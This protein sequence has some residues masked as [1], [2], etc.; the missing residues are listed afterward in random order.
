MCFSRTYGMQL[1]GLRYFNIFGPKQD[2]NGEYAAV[3]PLFIKAL[4]KNEAPF[5]N[6]DGEQ[7]RDFTYVHNAVQANVLAMFSHNELAYNQA[8]NIA[9][10]GRFSINYMYNAIQKNLEKDIKANYRDAR[11]GDI[12]D[13]QA[14]IS[15]AM[16]LLNYQ[17]NYTF[18]QGLPNTIEYF[19]SIF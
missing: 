6:G 10:G 1:I 13:S 17:P 9:V 4:L 12:R 5:I 8:Y 15:K 2:P 11:L 19:K 18:E 7:T 14:D 16:H 3:M